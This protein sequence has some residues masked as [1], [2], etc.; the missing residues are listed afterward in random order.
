M[1][2]MS[3]RIDAYAHIG[4]PRFAAAEELIRELDRNGVQKAIVAAADTCPDIHEILR[5]IRRYPDR[6]RG[7]G[8]PLGRTF[9]ELRDS[10]RQQAACGFL[11]IRIF[12]RMIAE[13]PEL[14]Q[15]M[16]ELKLVPYVVGGA[17]LAPAASLLA[18]FLAGAPDRL[19]VAPHF[20][21]AAD[22]AVLDAPG[23]VR[24]LF[25]HPRL[26]VIFS[27]HGAYDAQLVQSWASALIEKAGPERILYGS[28][29]PVCLWRNES[30]QSTLNWAQTLDPAPD[31]DRF[32]GGNARRYLWEKSL[33][34]ASPIELA[35]WVVPGTVR[36]FGGQGIDLPEAIQQE[37]LAS[38]LQEEGRGEDYRA[39]ITRIF[40]ERLKETGGP[41]APVRSVPG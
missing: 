36:L 31:P 32:Y 19:V 20:G 8:V 40:L 35:G 25:S 2:A 27:R 26:L 24:D 3:E 33:P 6:L 10:L 13:F 29:F 21:G 11:G 16:A 17:G 37:L 28:E 15:E 18:D 22:P 39:Y 38:Y 14:L 7:V 34:P 23:P 41:A 9:N 4:L 1:D 12:D 5:A 30:Y